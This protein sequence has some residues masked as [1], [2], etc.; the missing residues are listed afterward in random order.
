MK[1]LIINT[2]KAKGGAARAAFRL[3]QAVSRF[4]SDA[5]YLHVYQE[6]PSW[7]NKVYYFFRVLWD[8]LPAI[9]RSKRYI[10]FSSGGPNNKR[11]VETINNSNADIIHV[12]WI[13][14]GAL[15][16]RDIV[17]I[18]KPIVWSLHDMWLFTGGCHYDNDCGAYKSGCGNCPILASKNEKDLSKTNYEA[19]H[20]MV[21]DTLNLTVVGLSR[22]IAGAAKSSRMMRD[23]EVVNLPNAIDVSIFFPESKSASKAKVGLSET[24]KVILFGALSSTDDCRKGYS[25]LL[26]ALKGLQH[27]NNIQL[28]TFGGGEID[29]SVLNIEIKSVGRISDDAALRTVYSAADVV[30]VPSIQENLSNIIMESM[31]CGTPVVGFDIGGNSDLIQHKFTGYLADVIDPKSLADGIEWVLFQNQ[32]NNLNDNARNFV[33]DNFSYESVGA[34]YLHLYKNVLEKSHQVLLD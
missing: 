18:N 5:E 15:S 8:R 22:W 30:V 20:K 3:Y 10:Y 4:V 6:N 12:H 26:D 28:A 7:L 21:N 34:K 33:I 16:Y 13:N 25:Q 23:I 11:L 1:I 19:K 32:E 29:P 9:I 2:Y 14:A 17:K 31:A 24:K 27:S